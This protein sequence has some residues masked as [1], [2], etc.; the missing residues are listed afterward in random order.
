MPVVGPPRPTRH[1]AQAPRSVRL[2]CGDGGRSAVIGSPH[3]GGCRCVIAGVPLQGSA[4][5]CLAW[6][7]LGFRALLK[8]SAERAEPFVT[9]RHTHDGCRCH[10]A[11]LIDVGC[12]Q[13]SNVVVSLRNRASR[14][15]QAVLSSS[16]TASAESH[17]SCSSV[18]P[19][20]GDNEIKTRHALEMQRRR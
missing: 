9:S 8:R 17:H 1:L 6:G 12:K 15:C 4:S 16:E 10:Q 20:R 7:H 14:L 19:L 5:T 18:V 2:R 3:P 13:A 11:C